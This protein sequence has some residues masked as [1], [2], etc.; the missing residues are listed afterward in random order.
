MSHARVSVLVPLALLAALSAPAHATTQVQWVTPMA[1]DIVSGSGLQSINLDETPFVSEDGVAFVGKA[2]GDDSTGTVRVYSEIDSRGVGGVPDLLIGSSVAMTTSSGTLLSSAGG[3]PVDVTFV[4]SFDGSFHTYSGNV[5][6][7]L[8]ATL[9]LSVPS[10]TVAFT[11]VTYQSQLT[12]RTDLL[13]ETAVNTESKGNVTYFEPG[14]VYVDE[15]YASASSTVVS[16]DMDDLIGEVRLTVTM[17]PGQSFVLT[18]GLSTQVTPEPILPAS[19]AFDY[20]QSW[21]AVDGFNTGRLSILLPEG[22]AL[23]GNTGLLTNAVVAPPVPEPA[24]WG[25]MAA[26]LAVLGGFARR[27]AR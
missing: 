4:L 12:F 7:Q 26:G 9:T 16:D 25:M 15:P 24:S 20:S 19:G 10:A 21:G 2:Q 6:H 14:F 13:D 17:A 11:N 1:D 3:G 18:N 8:V 23:E 22:Y 27:R 5:F